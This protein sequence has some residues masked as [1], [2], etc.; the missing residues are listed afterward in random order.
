MCAWTERHATRA[1]FD[2]LYLGVAVEHHGARRLYQRLGFT[3]AGP[4]TTTTYQYVDNYGRMQWA[5]ETDNIF[6]KALA[7][8]GPSGRRSASAR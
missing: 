7:E 2:K 5:T 8:Y 4:T 1:G 3:S 6:E